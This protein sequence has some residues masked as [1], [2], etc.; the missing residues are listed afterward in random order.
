MATY[1]IVRR[2]HSVD[3]VDVYGRCV[4]TVMDPGAYAGAPEP[5]LEASD[6]HLVELVKQGEQ[7]GRYAPEN[8]ETQRT[9]DIVTGAWSMQL[10]PPSET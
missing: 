2:A 8:L 9:Y 10:W 6:S 1:R 4:D 7:S 5:Q 3:I